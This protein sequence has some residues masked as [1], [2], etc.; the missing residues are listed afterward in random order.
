[1]ADA[2]YLSLRAAVP[3]TVYVPLAQQPIAGLV[4]SATLSVRAA[5][6]PPELLAR[7]LGDAIARMDSR[8]AIT[9]TPLKQQVDAAL[10]HSIWA[11][12]L[13]AALLYGVEPRDPAT[14]MGAALVL[15]LVLVT[16]LTG[17]VPA[18]RAS[19]IDPAAVLKER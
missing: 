3:P 1:V 5:S 18:W 2:T 14:L 8:I 10:V 12:R 16:A 7:S 4:S 9:F 6:G 13:V 19:R 11:S 15:V 17:A